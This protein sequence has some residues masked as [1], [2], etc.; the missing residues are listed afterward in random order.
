MKIALDIGLA[1][2]LIAAYKIK[3]VNHIL[4][5]VVKIKLV[6]LTADLIAGIGPV[7]MILGS[8]P[9]CAQATIFAMG[10]MP[11]SCAVEYF[12]N[13][14]PAAPSLIPD[15][16]PAVTDPGVRNA[17]LSFCNFSSFVP[18]LGCS[19]VETN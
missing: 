2:F 7:P 14:T 5:L 3:M 15:E 4:A 6:V 10:A 16:L 12:I 11:R 1:R 9:A 18:C 13:K 17:A 19:S 8:T